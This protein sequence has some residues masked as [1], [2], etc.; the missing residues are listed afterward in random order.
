MPGRWQGWRLGT[1]ALDDQVR[2]SLRKGLEPP[3]PLQGSVHGFGFVTWHIANDIATILP[4]L[5]VEVRPVTPLSHAAERPSF[6]PL[7][8]CDFFK[9]LSW[10]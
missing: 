2:I 3:V 4:R 8:L 1:G 7:D 6:H 5:V 10:R 9:Q